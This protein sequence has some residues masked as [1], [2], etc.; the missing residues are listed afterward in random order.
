MGASVERE[1]MV[2]SHIR[3]TFYLVGKQHNDIKPSVATS[4]EEFEKL[5]VNAI[6]GMNVKE[7]DVRAMVRPRA[8]FKNWIATDIP[9]VF[10]LS[11]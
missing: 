4:L 10:Q 11:Q 6:E 2:F 8:A 7:E 5:S 3:K 9:I 1:H